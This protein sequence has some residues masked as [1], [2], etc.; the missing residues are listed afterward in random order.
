MGSLETILM[1]QA[2][3][4]LLT[5][6]A[7]ELLLKLLDHATVT[8]IIHNTII[9]K[10][11]ELTTNTLKCLCLNLQKLPVLTFPPQF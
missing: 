11:L 9:H 1:L 5:S 2:H 6:R 7:K 8:Y 4:I 10:I 3:T